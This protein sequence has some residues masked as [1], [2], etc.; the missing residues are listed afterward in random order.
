MSFLC[1]SRITILLGSQ[2]LPDSSVVPQP[3]GGKGG[4]FKLKQKN[5]DISGS[6]FM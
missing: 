3:G 6:V 5:H 1:L 4:H 2:E